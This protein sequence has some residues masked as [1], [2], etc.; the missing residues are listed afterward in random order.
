MAKIY[1]YVLELQDQ[2][3]VTL[4][5]QYQILTV[6]E[7]DGKMVLY[8]KVKEE[9]VTKNVTILIRGTGHEIEENVNYINTVK[10][11]YY[12]WHVFYK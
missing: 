6:I 10:M 11:G 5:E 3:F 12:V 8:A 4:P 7:Q 9:K 2:Q 1:K